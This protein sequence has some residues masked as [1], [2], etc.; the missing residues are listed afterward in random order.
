MAHDGGILHA[1][2]SGFKGLESD[3]VILADLDPEDPRCSPADLYVTAS[4]AKDVLHQVGKR[5]GFA[6]RHSSSA[7]G[8]TKRIESSFEN[9]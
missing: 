9:T 3:A 1:T 8:L 2:I 6:P 7:G 4:R 5:Q